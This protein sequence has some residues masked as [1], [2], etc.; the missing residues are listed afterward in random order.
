MQHPVSG[1]AHA[2]LG[3]ADLPHGLTMEPAT[4]AAIATPPGSGGVGIIRIS[5]A[6]SR[7]I[8]AAIFRRSRVPTQA[9]PDP[10]STALQSHRLYLGHIVDPHENAPVDEV[11]VAVMPAPRS[12]TKEDVVEIQS[13]SGYIVLNR[14][15]KLVLAQGARLADPGEFTRRAFMNGRIDL[16]QAEA[17]IDV[18]NARTDKSLDIAALQLT[19]SFGARI[20]G[21][22]D[23]VLEALAEIEA[24]ID[25]SDDLDGSA[26]DPG[27]VQ[28]I[29]SGVVEPLKALIDAYEHSHFLRDGVRMAIIGRPNVGKSSLLNCLTRKERAIVTAIPGTT[30]DTIE[31]MINIRGLPV[32]VIDTAGLHETAQQIEQMGIARTYATVQSADIVLLVVD[33]SQGVTQGDRDIF[34]RLRRGRHIVVVNK[35][36]LNLDLVL[37]P[38]WKSGSVVRVSALNGTHIDKL[39][40][41]IFSMAV[42]GGASHDASSLVPNLRQA[43]GLK[44]ALGHA[45]KCLGGNEKPRELALQAL[46]LAS[47]ARELDLILGLS[48]SEDV[49]DLIFDRFCIGK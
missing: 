12:Y 31:E 4:I 14:V 38:E 13:H 41:T 15:L 39:R 37:P 45:S 1:C 23:T 9:V 22:R 48:F 43:Q 11:L 35:E 7:N 27:W 19:G 6:E 24:D 47:T 20:N 33:P 42:G 18:I 25:F 34:Q 49:L 36:D 17:V 21:I 10:S 40:E 3:Q 5:G 46:D 28:R 32:I 29:Q 30:R 2:R 8:I 26:V 16:T 44:R